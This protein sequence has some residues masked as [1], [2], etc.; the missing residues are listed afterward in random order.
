MKDMNEKN[1]KLEEEFKKLKNELVTK[2]QKRFL[3]L[4]IQ[5]EMDSQMENARFKWQNFKRNIK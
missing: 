2:R 1:I 3:K 5:E 4:N